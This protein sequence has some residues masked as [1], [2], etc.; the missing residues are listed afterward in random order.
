MIEGGDGLI[1]KMQIF[2]LKRLRLKRYL[3]TEDPLDQAILNAALK[4]QL[5]VGIVHIEG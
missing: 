4:K 3:N 2:S 5:R 1:T